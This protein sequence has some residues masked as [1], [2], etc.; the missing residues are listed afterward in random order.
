[1]T[2]QTRIGM[3]EQRIMMWYL[4]IMP[5]TACT[6]KQKQ[7]DSQRIWSIVLKNKFVL[8]KMEN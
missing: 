3:V 8:V 5:F 2:V 7:N 6:S 4:C 1:M